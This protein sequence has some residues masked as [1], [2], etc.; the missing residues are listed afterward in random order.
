MKYKNIVRMSL[1]SRIQETLQQGKR[2][3]I[4]GWQAVENRQYLYCYSLDK[5]WLTDAI[6]SHEIE[7]LRP[8]TPVLIVS[9]TGTGKTTLLF[10]HCLP[11]ALRRKRRILYLCNRI[12]LA[13]QMKERC[14]KDEL[15]SQQKAGKVLVGGMKEYYTEKF[16]KEASDFGGIHILTYQKFLMVCEELDFSEYEYIVLDEAHFFLSD[17]GFNPYTEAIMDKILEK[18]AG[19]SRIYLTATPHECMEMLYRKEANLLENHFP[20]CF[21]F[22]KHFSVFVMDEDYSYMRPYFFKTQQY[23]MD[24]IRASSE[25]DNWLIFVRNKDR[26]AEMR[27]ALKNLPGGVA[28][29]TADS[30]KN[31]AEYQNL[32]KNEKLPARVLIT[33]KVLDVG[34]N[35]RTEHLRIV[36]FEDNVVELKQMIGRKRIR[37]GENLE[38]FFQLPM[39]S[40][41]ERREGYAQKRYEDECRVVQQLDYDA[42]RYI[43]SLPHPLYYQ[44]H[45]IGINTL[46][47]EKSRHDYF[48]YKDLIEELE[49][50]S[51]DEY[52]IKY[53]EK[54]LSN[55]PKQVFRPEMIVEGR[56]ARTL[57]LGEMSEMKAK[58]QKLMES[59]LS[60]TFDKEEL[61]VFS[62]EL[63]EITGDPRDDQRKDRGVPAKKT[64]NDILV[65][66]GYM[67]ESLNV[68]PTEYKCVILEKG[69]VS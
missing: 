46:S 63:I 47:L 23:I 61:K 14:M 6:S 1:W 2:W 25:D 17:A 35:I 37:A 50:Y 18:A 45:D 4:R 44:G 21:D 42:Y 53:A 56:I 65:K 51:E 26:G 49:P 30:D 58:V 7:S 52:Q 43:I 33:T 57:D 8:E 40:E 9:Q 31:F 60:R 32:I 28:Y 62:K 5:E 64:L 11:V 36:L 20:W 19:V 67:V 10:K 55:F 29:I 41:L 27:E 12:S 34:V 24:K 54:L 48:S 3:N 38:V 68:S 16:L 39:L 15:N 22:D 69:S 66:F 13:D 59:W